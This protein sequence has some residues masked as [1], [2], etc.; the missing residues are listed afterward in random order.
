MTGHDIFEL[1]MMEPV[2]WTTRAF[3]LGRPASIFPVVLTRL[4]GTPAR[5]E[6][7]VANVSEQLLGLRVADKWSVK[8]H[9]GHLTDLQELEE[10]R[11]GEFL[12]GAAVLSPAD[13]KNR[14]T[15]SANHNQTGIANLLGRLRTVRF[16]WVAKL[17]NLTETDLLRAATHP[18]LKQKMSLVDW[19]YFVAEHDDHHLAWVTHLI[20]SVPEAQ[21]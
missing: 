2:P 6:D 11:L 9:L 20:K 10:R 19:V 12:N 21:R 18:R 5:A 3:T 16:E 4:R 7:L 14:A 15:E 17:E 1:R 13:M 8:E